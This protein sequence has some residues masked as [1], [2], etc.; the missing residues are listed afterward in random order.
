MAPRSRNQLKVPVAVIASGLQ[1]VADCLKSD[2]EYPMDEW[3]GLTPQYDINLWST[4]HKHYAT[5]YEARDGHTI[6]CDWLPIF[7]LAIN[8]IKE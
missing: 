6:S 5:I 3:W 4:F 2:L 7:E 8:K 1:M